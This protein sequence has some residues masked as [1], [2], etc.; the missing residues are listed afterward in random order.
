[1][2]PAAPLGA[3][4]QYSLMVRIWSFHGRDPGSIPGIGNNLKINKKSEHYS[5][6]ANGS[7]VQWSVRG[8]LNPETRVRFSSGLDQINNKQKHS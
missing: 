8:T 3:K 1:M 5:F 6:N 7:V 4:F 2:S